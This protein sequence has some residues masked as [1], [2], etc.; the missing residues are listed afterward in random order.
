MYLREPNSENKVRNSNRESDMLLR[1]KSK[2]NLVANDSYHGSDAESEHMDSVDPLVQIQ[3]DIAQTLKV[4][5]AKQSHYKQLNP[6]QKTFAGREDKDD[7]DSWLMTLNLNLLAA[8]IPEERKLIEAAGFFQGAAQTFYQQMM[9]KD[10]DI[11]WEDFQVELK[12]R[13]RPEDFQS[14]IFEQLK[15][16]KQ[17]GSLNDYIDQFTILQNK[18]ENLSELVLISLFKDGLEPS[19]KE[20]LAYKNPKTLKDAMYRAKRFKESRRS[21]SNSASINYVNNGKNK[22]KG[23]CEYCNIL[24]HSKPFCFKYKRMQE[25]N[26]YSQNAYSNYQNNYN[27]QN[28]NNNNQIK[29]I[30]IIVITTKIIRIS[31][32][33]AAIAEKWDTQTLTVTQD[34]IK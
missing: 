20:E 9:N 17:T 8:E 7:V 25:A 12:K 13:F 28:N 2:K 10:K 24:G 6:T 32:I 34:K 5:V 18:S 1:T 3:R 19:L 21:N 29:I 22:Y 14:R 27:H 33:D 23:R 31:T 15:Q 16:L 26:N 4:L 30:V 11:T